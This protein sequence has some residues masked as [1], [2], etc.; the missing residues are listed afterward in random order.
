[1]Q[2]PDWVDFEAFKPGQRAFHRNMTNML[3]AYAVGSAVEGF[4]TMVA[5]SYSITGHAPN[6]GPGAVRRLG[7]NNRHMIETYFP[8]GL[9]RD[10][11][12]WKVNT[13]IRFIHDMGP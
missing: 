11:A 8:G 5:K 10:D 3:I 7:Q 4:G 1:M 6:L 2:V 9:L 12:G 13:R